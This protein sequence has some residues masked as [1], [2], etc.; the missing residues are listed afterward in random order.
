[1]WGLLLRKGVIV[2]ALVN[3]L[4]NRTSLTQLGQQSRHT[5]DGHARRNHRRHAFQHITSGVGD[6]AI[7]PSENVSLV[8]LILDLL[9]GGLTLGGI[10]LHRLSNTPIDELGKL[11]LTLSQQNSLNSLE[12]RTNSNFSISHGINPFQRWPPPLI[13]YLLYHKLGTLSRGFFKSL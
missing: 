10:L 7:H 8:A 4:D 13:S 5:I 9:G 6:T 3:S 2:L 12:L 11:G 1:M